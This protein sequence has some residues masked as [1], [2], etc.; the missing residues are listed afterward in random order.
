MWISKLELIC[1]KSYQQQTFSFPE[2]SDEKNVVLIG[3]LNGYGKT[4]ILEALYL[5]LYG[6]DAIVHLA[7]AGL[8]SD[9]K[10]GY[11]T[12]LERAFNG[13]AKRDGLDTMIVRVVINRS[14]TKAVDISRKWFFRTN[15]TWTGEEEA[16]VRNVIRDIPEMPRIDG[17]SN[18]HLSD[19]LDEIFV[20]AHV[21]PFFFFDGE[22]VKK[23]A[24]QSRI[25]Q[26]KH[27][28]EGL[29]GVVLLRS[30]ADR[31]KNYEAMKR[32]D[33][34]SVNEDN[35]SKLL[36]SL[37]SNQDQLKL[38]R[39]DAERSEEEKN[40]LRAEQQSL[41]E[42]I[43]AAG[44]GGGDIATVKELVEEREQ[45]RNKLRDSQKKLEDIL[46]GRLPFHLVPKALME[47]FRNQ[48]IAESKYDEWESEKRTLEP[49]RALFENA[50]LSETKPNIQ[51]PLTDEQIDAIKE[52]IE[53][54]W[55][56]LFY[57][58]PDDC[59]KETVHAYLHEP[60]R[61]K[62]LEFLSTINLG[63]RE[64]HD[65]LN[66][67]H[68]LQQ[69]ADELG[70]KISRLEGIDHDGTLSSLKKQLEDI[71]KKLDYLA[72]HIRVD[73]RKIAAL[74]AQ[75]S[76]QSAE[77]QREQ[78]KLDDSSPVRSFIQKSERVRK[79][80]DEVIPALFPL[81]VGELAKA[82]TVVYKQLAH[83]DQ[84]AKIEIFDDGTTKILGKT[85]NEVSFDR[86][87]GENQ[88]FA[89]ALIAGLAKVSGVNAPMVVDTP[90]GRLDSKHRE[91]ILRFWTADKNRQVILL[92][93]DEEIDFHFYKQIADSV[94]KTYLLEHLDVGD[95]IGRTSAK[96]DQYFARG[97]R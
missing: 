32:S 3:G 19:L 88:I 43:T 67:Q 61:L 6:K 85:G 84:V 41:I 62:A 35:L 9:D 45:I 57:P 66:L 17:K 69:R 31:L 1:F 7:R 51:P 36:D 80:I 24:D 15:G 46:S 95:G 40:H 44:G 18:F 13:E 25:E 90:L 49:K 82:M 87:A 91:N 16:I 79:V 94:C 77:Y 60:L 93:Q 26:V 4:S 12:F 59:A 14:K 54:A 52:R 21:A 2:P 33:V 92:S 83:K 55:T 42:R 38:L 37:L 47:G 48:L 28:L 86:S 75:V 65:L 34:V 68:D 27:G 20:P 30:L 10:K 50:F 11:P 74:D 56:S 29:L 22:E 89:T 58:P 64:I 76:A 8:K 81:K 5:C 70:R 96:E 63:Q 23:L 97:R 71:Q 78:K 39:D 73:D 53:T 72:D